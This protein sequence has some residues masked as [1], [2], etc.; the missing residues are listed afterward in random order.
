MPTLA[1]AKKFL[2]NL[3]GKSFTDTEFENLC[4]DFGI[5]LDDITSEREMFMREQGAAVDC[6]K[7]TGVVAAEK[8]SDEV[9]YKIDTPANRY[10]LLSAEG[11]SLAL[12][13]FLG[14]LPMPRFTVLNKMK[15]LY[16][17]TVEKK[18]KSIRPY[19]VCAVLKNI[20]FNDYSYNSFIDLQEKLHSGLARRRTLASVG[21]H[22]LDKINMSS[23]LYTA[24]PKEK[25]SFI[26]LRQTKVM[27]CAGDGLA[28]FFAE[29]RH[30]GKYVPLIS[31]FPDYP[32]IMDGAGQQVLSLPPI[33][34]SSYSAIS[35][36]TKNIFIECTATDHRKAQ[37]LVNQM[38]CAF[39]MYCENPFSVEAV[40]VNYEETCE[41]GTKTEVCPPMNPFD[42]E[43]DVSR[44][45]Q[46]L[47]VDVGS[48]EDCANLL[49]KMMLGIN[50][51]KENSVSVSVPPCRADIF[52]PS[53]LIED[54]GIAY[55][56]S[57][58]EF[59]ECTTHGAVTQTPVSKV[60][61]LIR[62]ELAAAGYTE[63]LTY[64]LCSRDDAFSHLQR[65]DTDVAV[66]IAN[67]QTMEFQICRPTL[68][69]GM[70]KT[71]SANKSNPLPHR[72]FECADVVLLDNEKNFP[73]VLDTTMDKCYPSSG[74]RNQRRLAALHCGSTNSSCFEMIHGLTEFILLKFSIPPK[75]AATRNEEDSYTVEAS[76]EDGAF[77]EGRGMAVF[78]HR[79]NQKVKI[80]GLGVVHPK[81]LK[82]FDIPYPCSYVELNIQ[83]LCT[84]L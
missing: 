15:P 67:P 34:N 51:V 23:F 61:H 73:P 74:A 30:I 6:E 8:L 17:M 7:R 18:V 52:G 43:M 69:V 4:F 62:Q 49:K 13:V 2:C 82:H 47:G 78:L 54:V 58:I 5:E 63:L 44:T 56:Y 46:R 12:R 75:S 65:Q 45:K 83:F 81:S 37:V 53:D 11:M 27:N 10:D 21:T 31:S 80:G 72:F 70:L 14:L 3:I 59:T 55:G 24:L 42:M 26:P 48:A 16:T 38:V 60:G 29:D 35:K 66:H 19:V 20:S 36:A 25:I 76:D 77:F 1:V 64:S 22:D 39:S 33:I 41:D 32:V 79:K 50:E 84:E 9:L 71:L 57:N 28:Q 68:L 40:Q